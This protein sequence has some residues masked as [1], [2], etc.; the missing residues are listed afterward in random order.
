MTATATLTQE[1]ESRKLA[2]E[3]AFDQLA[4]DLVDGKKPKAE[5]VE[6][7][8]DGAEKNPADLDAA[9]ELV[10]RRRSLRARLDAKAAAEKEIV[11]FQEAIAAEDAKLAAARAR[12]AAATRPHLAKLAAARQTVHSALMVDNEL[13][14]TAPR[15]IRNPLARL[16]A[17]RD[18]LARKANAVRQRHETFASWTRSAKA[19]AAA[20]RRGD[21][22]ASS[23]RNQ[24]AE[25]ED[26]QAADY[27]RKA[28]ALAEEL[29][30]IESELAAVA[31][32]IDKL[33]AE[34]LNP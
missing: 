32:Q 20:F 2:R 7:I 29:E 11:G 13:R 21:L 24:T 14:E 9:V 19:Q 30:Q 18:Q 34:A 1:L 31:E 10:R 4:R 15:S 28:M 3:A 17:E 23:E 26:E 12:H 27:E 16:Y 25:R 8:L 6:A 22:M 33:E 5:A